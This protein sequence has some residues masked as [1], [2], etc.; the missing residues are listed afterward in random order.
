MDIGAHHPT[1]FSNTYY[2][3]KRGCY[4]FNVDILPGTEMLFERTRPR[5]TTIECSVG[6]QAGELKYF[7]FNEPALNTFFRKR[8]EK[9]RYLS[10]PYHQYLPDSKFDFK[11]NIR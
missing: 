10:I 5:D 6:M 3:Y 8:G 11:A 2:F 7:A 1:R 9:E 4:G